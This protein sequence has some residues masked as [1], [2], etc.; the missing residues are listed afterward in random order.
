MFVLE[1]YNQVLWA[2]QQKSVKFYYCVIT[3][4]E[5]QQIKKF[6]A[7]EHQTERTALSS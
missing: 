2:N 4:E 1:F 5:K 7:S 3:N 6:N